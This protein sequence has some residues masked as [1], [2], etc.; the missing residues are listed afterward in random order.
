MISFLVLALDGLSM[1][2]NLS[3]TLACLNNIGPGLDLVGPTGNY[4][5]FSDG[6][7]IVLML[8]MLLGRLEIFP[9]LV[10]LSP[11]TWRKAG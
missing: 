8:D 4:A 6:S 10:M 7:K 5:M 9:L 1:E 2:T 11:Y 3:A